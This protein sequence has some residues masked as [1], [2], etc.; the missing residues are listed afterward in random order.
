VSTIHRV[1]DNDLYEDEPVVSLKRSGGFFS[2]FLRRKDS[3]NDSDLRRNRF[4]YL[5]TADSAS[6]SGLSR[7]NQRMGVKNAILKKAVK[8]KVSQLVEDEEDGASDREE[9]LMS[10][11]KG[12]AG[13]FEDDEERAARRKRESR[14]RSEFP[15]NVMATRLL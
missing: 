13:G 15:V 3:E 8:L 14:L 9:M 7:F 10:E 12:G 11:I 2:N 4:D 5:K 1:D 6:G